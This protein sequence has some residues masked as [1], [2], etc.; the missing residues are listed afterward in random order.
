ML[1][2]ILAIAAFALATISPSQLAAQQ[3][4][5]APLQVAVIDTGIARTEQLA[6]LMGPSWDMRAS[7]RKGDKRIGSEHGTFVAGIIA[8]RV[9]R[10]IQITSFRVDV[11]CRRHDPCQ[12]DSG[13]VAAAIRTSIRMDMDLIQISIDGRLGDPAIEAMRQAA[14]AGIQIVMSSG[15]DGLRSETADAASGLGPNV[16][17]VGALDR[18]GNRADFTSYSRRDDV[19]LVMRQGV[20]VEVRD[21]N[22]RMTKVTGTS[23]AAPIYA[24]ELLE[25]M[26]SRTTTEL[27]SAR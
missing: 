25:A 10:P 21:S 20:D 24:A 3:T 1:R 27:A 13:A 9:T 26:P 8:D 11:R 2:K 7:N 4:D 17:V 23:F 19:V 12:L 22:G 15:N 16:H 14:E 18:N 5:L 6:P